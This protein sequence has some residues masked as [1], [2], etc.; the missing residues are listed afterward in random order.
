MKEY[1]KKNNPKDV[2]Y[3]DRDRRGIICFIGSL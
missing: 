3:G 1:L 2:G